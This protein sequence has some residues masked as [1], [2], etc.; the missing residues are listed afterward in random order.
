MDLI[1]VA[2]IVLTVWAAFFVRDMIMLLAEPGRKVESSGDGLA[3]ELGNAGT[4]RRT[5]RS[6]ATS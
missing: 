3:E 5:Y 6:S 4:R 2:L 1:A